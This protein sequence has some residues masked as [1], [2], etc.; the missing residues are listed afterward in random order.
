MS[1]LLSIAV[2][3]CG[4][5]YALPI[6]ENSSIR[7]SSAIVG[8]VLETEVRSKA[9]RKTVMQ[10]ERKTIQKPK[11]FF[12]AGVTSSFSCGGSCTAV[13]FIVV[14]ILIVDTLSWLLIR[15]VQGQAEWAFQS[16]F[17]TVFA[18]DVRIGREL[19]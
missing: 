8:R 10:R 6:Q 3:L 1:F 16:A 19:T 15:G 4:T 12:K 11:S 5:D 9:E 14:D 17:Y 18:R 2:S 7:N 13:V